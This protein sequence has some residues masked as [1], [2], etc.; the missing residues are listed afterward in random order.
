MASI[1]GSALVNNENGDAN[2]YFNFLRFLRKLS[3]VDTITYQPCLWL[4]G[5]YEILYSVNKL[6]YDLIP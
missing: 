5:H 3:I 1:D 6:K 4:K 2:N